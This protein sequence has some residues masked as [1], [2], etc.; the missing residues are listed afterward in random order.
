MAPEKTNEEIG[1]G[2][3]EPDA[4]ARFPVLVLSG[5]VCAGK[6]TLARG[7][8]E[9]LGSGV[10]TTRALIAKHVDHKPDQLERKRLQEIG[11]ELDR[12][13]GGAWISEAL[14]ELTEARGDEMV[15]IDA[16]RNAMQVAAVATFGPTVHVHLTADKSDLAARY[17]ARRQSQPQLEFPSFDALRIN[18]TEASIEKLGKAADLI[19]DTSKMDPDETREAVLEVIEHEKRAES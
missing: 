12:V 19:I 6:S 5:P 10:L 16:V 3:A 2:G 14:R 18:T 9:R 1:G 13:K 8:A 4:A 17:L 7:L 15:V 11:D